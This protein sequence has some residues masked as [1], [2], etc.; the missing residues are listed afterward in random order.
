MGIGFNLFTN[1]KKAYEW[2][3]DE[4]IKQVELKNNEF[5]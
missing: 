5:E 1:L 2:Q 4:K 3:L